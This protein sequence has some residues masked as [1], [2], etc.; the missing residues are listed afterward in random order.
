MEAAPAGLMILDE[1]RCIVRLSALMN[2]GTFVLLELT[3]G[4]EVTSFVLVHWRMEA[5]VVQ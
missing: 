1:L 4:G 3:P 5:D 2:G